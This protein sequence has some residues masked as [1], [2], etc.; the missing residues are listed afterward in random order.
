MGLLDALNTD[1][2]RLGLSLLAAGGY[3]PT[4]MSV[5][6]RVQM[7]MQGLDAQKRGTLQ[8][9]LLESQ[10]SENA[11]QADM[12][13]QQLLMSQRQMDL[14]NRLLGFG[15]PQGAG[16]MPP[17]GMQNLPQTGAPD[18][19]GQLGT[20]TPGAQPTPLGGGQQGG[21][22]EALSKQ[23]G[24]PPEALQYDLVFNGG[25]GIAEMVSKRGTPDM[26]V[27]NG[28]A[29][30]KN[31]LGAGYLPQLNVSQDGKTSMVRIGPDGLPVVSA[32]QGAL[33]T[34]GGYQR[35]QA[36]L[37]PIKVYNPAT[38]REEYSNEAA[39]AQPGGEAGMRAAVQG[40]M[41]ADP[42]AIQREIAA[43]RNDLLKPLDP[44]SRAS[45]QAHLADLLTQAQRTPAPSGNVAAGPSAA[46][47]A[48]QKANEA[49]AVDTAKA[50]VV[51][52]TT[53]ATDA[54]RYGQLTAGVSRAIELLKAGPTAS[55]AGSLYDAAQGFFGES[56]KG[57]D[58]ASQLDTLSG[59][60]TANVPRMEGPQS[61]RDV[62]QYKIQAAAVGDRTKP[63][64]QR[65]KAAEELQSLQNKYAA[66]NGMTPAQAP[67]AP[68]KPAAAAPVATMRYN[69]ATG[70]LEKVQ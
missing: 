16:Y 39:V 46:E 13:K 67:G 63:V 45:L 52:D 47:A 41:G 40:G 3:S 22:L 2:A 43:T 26:Q 10:I 60:L 68:D 64:S 54:K 37:K 11:S 65:L 59:W 29:Y 8:N 24:I 61:D 25:K 62:M 70:K 5:G 32:P 51:R 15:S 28:Y 58:L 34:F 9:K 48:I 20:A 38:G 33:D 69:P 6:Q 23:Y 31:R 17:S 55:G 4:P 53:K 27:S 42:M 50:D 36:G 35:A 44:S 66:L 19:P 1:E 18:A 12:R 49:R 57:A 56:N 30:D 21:T 14:Q 7:A